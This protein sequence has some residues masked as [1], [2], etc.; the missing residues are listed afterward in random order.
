MESNGKHVTRGG[1]EVSYDTSPIYWGE[2]GTNGQHSFYQLIHQGT[3]LVPCD[4][5][6]FAKA[7]TPLGRH[8]D[9][10][11][12]NVLAQSRSARVRQDGGRGACG[13]NRRRACAA[14]RVPGQ[15][16]VEHDPRGA[17]DARRRSAALVALYE[18][19][20]FT[21]GAIWDINSLRPM[22]RRARQ[23]ARASH[24]SRARRCDA[25]RNSA[26]QLDEQPDPP[27]SPAPGLA[28]GLS[29]FAV[30]ENHA[31]IAIRRKAGPA[32]AAD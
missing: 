30:G 21:Q 24:H 6:A 26:R 16:T 29:L 18:H 7:L 19:I 31:A 4:F 32:R 9:V 10:L 1:A 12:A 23:S 25:S 14:S 13:G 3:R 2:P 27:L 15:P 17:L 11:I 28:S 20:V 5:I 22:G 8:H